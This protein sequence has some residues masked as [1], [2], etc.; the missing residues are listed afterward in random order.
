MVHQ[1]YKEMFELPITMEYIDPNP[2]IYNNE[3]YTP[4]ETMQ[5]A[6]NDY[7]NALNVLREK[8]LETEDDNYARLLLDL[9][10][11]AVYSKIN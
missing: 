4:A 1:V 3:P 11:A 7:L 9:V 8:F 6:L 2:E 10:P 5:D